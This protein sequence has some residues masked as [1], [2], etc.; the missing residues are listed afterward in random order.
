MKHEAFIIASFESGLFIFP[1]GCT[2]CDIGTIKAHEMATKA[3]KEYDFG[4]VL[5]KLILSSYVTTLKL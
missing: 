2:P 5:L 1:E 4:K 3:C